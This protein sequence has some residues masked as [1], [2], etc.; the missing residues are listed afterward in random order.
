MKKTLFLAILLAL[1]AGPALA[2]FQQVVEFHVKPG[3]E[4]AFENYVKKVK[5]GADKI[6]SPLSWSTFSVAVG[7][8]VSTYRIALGFQKWSERDRWQAPRNILVQAFGEQEGAK[9]FSS[10]QSTIE[11]STSRIWERIDDGTANPQQ[12]GTGTSAFYEVTIRHVKPEMLD[13][14]RGLL[15]RFKEAYEASDKKPSVTRWILRY[16][17]GQNTTFRRTQP[18]SS[19]GELDTWSAPEVI[20]KHF[21]ADAPLIFQRLNDAVRETEHFVSAFRPDLSRSAASSTSN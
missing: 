4:I 7:R 13:E 1:V 20:T 11:S 3:Q 14:Y 16:G 2:Q 5:E 18:F 10:G 19:W 12:A 21:G 15:R 17:T 8:E 6:G 9:L